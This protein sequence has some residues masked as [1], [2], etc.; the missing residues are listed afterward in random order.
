[1][2]LDLTEYLFWFVQ[3]SWNI[4]RSISWLAK[5]LSWLVLVHESWN[6]FWY[7][8]YIYIE[9]SKGFEYI[10]IYIL[11]WLNIFFDFPKELKYI[12]YTT[13]LALY[14]LWLVQGSWN[15]FDI[16]LDLLSICFDLSKGVKIYFDLHL[17]L[18]KY[19]FWLPK[20]VNF[21]LPSLPVPNWP[22]VP[23]MPLDRATRPTRSKLAFAL[24]NKWHP[25]ISFF[26]MFD[27]VTLDSE[28]FFFTE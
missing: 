12:Q 7:I 13:W 20:G 6:I 28:W 4:F 9:W 10:L 21:T 17:N 22:L 1:M 24:R 27:I 11:T 14:L 15:I 5:Y 3:G 19:L 18:T 25:Y 26:F 8:L 16:D 23:Q 2:H